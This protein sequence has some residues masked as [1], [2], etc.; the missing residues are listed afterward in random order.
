MGLRRLR[1]RLD[2]MQGNANFTMAMAQDLIAD[3]K[4]GFGVSIEIDA[5][6]A[7]TLVGLLMGKAGT[8]PLKVKI[9]PEV[10]AK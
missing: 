10:D 4:D 8:L 7:Q 3:L 6:A 1:G 9:D 2:Q 5:G